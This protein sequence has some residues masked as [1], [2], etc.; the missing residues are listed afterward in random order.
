[1]LLAAGC[2]LAWGIIVEHSAT[3]PRGAAPPGVIPT[4]FSELTDFELVSGFSERRPGDLM[5][6]LPGS[7]L[8]LDAKKVLIQGFMMPTRLGKDMQVMEFLL[9]RSQA[10]CC[11]GRPLQLNEVV[12][13]R[14]TGHPARLMMDQ[15][16]SVIGIFH[17]R[18]RW[19][20]NVLGSIY[21][22]DAEAVVP[23]AQARRAAEARPYFP[24]PF[25]PARTRSSRCCRNR[26]RSRGA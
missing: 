21:Q 17:V 15:V 10:S 11:Y 3:S 4:S 5:K 25:N 18:E 20:G 26:D 13:V 14:M 1:M 19:Q 9:A 12:E 2:I 16:L 23:P 6:R 24:P 7:I 22:M 8:R